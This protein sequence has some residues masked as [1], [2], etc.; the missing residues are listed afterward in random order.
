[1]KNQK[2]SEATRKRWADPEK[3]KV[4]EKARH[5]GT[6]SRKRPIGF[7]C[8]RPDGYYNLKIDNKGGWALEHVYVL[9]N[10]IG[11]KLENDE[12]CHHRDENKGNNKPGNLLLK[13]K[14][15][16]DRENMIKKHTQGKMRQVPHTN[17]RK[18]KQ[19]AYMKQRWE[20]GDFSVNKK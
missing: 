2:S 17:E 1:M 15:D 9:E 10:K 3:R 12:V 14:S 7:R 16:H 6:E 19:S 13:K 11:R 4:L 5:N 18:Q 8:I 20:S